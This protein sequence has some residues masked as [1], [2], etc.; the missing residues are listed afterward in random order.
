MKCRS[1]IAA[2]ILLTCMLGCAWGQHGYTDFGEFWADTA[3]LNVRH[4]I[5]FDD[6]AVGAD[7]SVRGITEIGAEGFLPDGARLTRLTPIASNTFLPYSA[8]NSLGAAGDNQFLAG[9]SD[10]VTFSFARPVL[11]FGL[12]LIGNP[13]PTGD[14]PIPFWRMRPNLPVPIEVFSATEPLSSLGPGDDV[15]FLGIISEE[16]FTEAQLFSDNDEAAVFSFSVDNVIWCMKASEA[17]VAEAKFLEPGTEILLNDV[18]VT[19]VHSDRFNVEK[20]DRSSGLAVL[21]TGGLR[22]REVSLLGTIGVTSPD[23]ERVINLTQI[24][25]Q[26]PSTGLHPLGMTTRAVAGGAPAGLQIG[27]VGSVGLNSIGLD[28]SVTGV[29]TSVSADGSWFTLD[30][31]CAR[32]SGVGPTG[33]RVAGEIGERREGEYVKVS[34]SASL[35]S[36]A[37]GY[38][39]LIRVAHP[40]DIVSVVQR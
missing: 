17:S 34:G 11:A 6:L 16:P 29:V 27:C 40:K 2:L 5:T 32:D 23:N 9:N 30:D 26:V 18:T 20:R 36:A 4:T 37:A 19:R 13:S 3:R 1:A 28:V 39:P 25:N 24:I 38:F 15:Y 22:N 35:F 33:V 14:P 8:P 12:F 31:G 21:G 10:T 7:A